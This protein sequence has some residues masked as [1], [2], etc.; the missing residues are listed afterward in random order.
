M[1][2]KSGPENNRASFV[3]LAGV[4]A[5][6]GLVQ[7]P[8]ALNHDAAWHFYSAIRVLGGDR[9]G[10]DIADINPP[11]AM[12]LFSFPAMAVTGLGL[13][14]AMV[15][16]TFVLLVAG[17]IFLTIRTPLTLL[18]GRDATGLLLMIAAIFLLLPGYHFGQREHL[19]ALL[20]LPYVA[21]A[22]LRSKHH[23]VSAGAATWMGSLAAI[24]ICFK[25]YF[26]A[27]P[28]IVELWLIVRQRD[29]RLVL[30]TETL[31]MVAIGLLYVAAVFVFA[32]DYMYRVVPDALATYAGFESGL[33]AIFSEAIGVL[34][35]PALALL[36]SI[37][38]LR[39]VDALAG[40]LLAA[41]GGYLLA[42]L[43]QQK[44]WQYQI[45][46]ASLHIVASAAVQMV[47]AQRWRALVAAAIGLACAVP[48]MAFVWDGLS[49]NGTSARVSALEQV[50]NTS[51]NNSVYAFVTSPR[52][53]H[54]AVL[55]SG[56]VWA[57]AYGVAIFLPAHLQALEAEMPDP[58][59][60][61]AIAI[62]EAYLT[63]MLGRFA[64][65]PPGIL[66]FDASRFKLGILDSEHFDYLEFL[67]AY[68]AFAGLIARYEEITPVGRFRLFR[69]RS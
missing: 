42:A 18:A 51:P 24:G 21:L 53:M 45:M 54:P 28:L 38:A 47:L 67:A 34:I 46:P 35:F 66:G 32:P 4:F 43:L 40:M 29:L 61:R 11:M 57:D 3:G 12:W 48:A 6:A 65:S 5:L 20:T 19:A 33:N 25:P 69:L 52:D 13:S 60:Q 22:A 23:P 15:F 44:G 64:V 55:Q 37:M 49:P 30:R 58:R 26:L 2:L 31:V 63:E 10:L 14:P 62:S 9:I 16:K 8:F 17:M 36:F 56:N 68:P 59:H 7:F 39:R 50:L 1:I 27:V 41:A